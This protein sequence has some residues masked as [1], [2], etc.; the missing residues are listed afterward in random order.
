MGKGWTIS[1]NCMEKGR[2]GTVGVWGIGSGSRPRKG[3]GLI[4]PQMVR[5]RPGADSPTD[6]YWGG[7]VG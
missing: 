6:A 5:R 1:W 3:L 7:S 4:G 2:R